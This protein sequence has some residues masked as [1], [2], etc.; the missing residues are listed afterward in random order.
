MLDELFRLTDATLANA[1]PAV[2]DPLRTMRKAVRAH[3]ASAEDEAFLEQYLDS[4][5]EGYLLSNTP[6]EIA[7]HARVA[8]DARESIVTAAIIPSV[9]EEITE[10]CVVTGNPINDPLCVIAKDRPGLLASIAAAITS[11]GFDVHA[12]QIHTRQMSDGR[13]QAMDLF[14]VTSR[15]PIDDLDTALDKLRRDLERVITGAVAPS[16]LLRARRTRFS[17][18]PIPA[19]VTEVTIDN[20]TST[21]HTIVEIVTRDRPGLLFTLART[22]HELDLTIGVAKINT[23]GTRVLD[24]FHVTD[25]SGRKI[26]ESTRGDCVRRALLAALSSPPPSQAST[27]SVRP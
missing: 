26:D 27:P 20:R 23:E 22:F 25:L 5:P 7:L 14:W 24:A 1:S 16:D 11:N 3:W 12:A 2:G 21:T 8:L 15:A 18:R 9:R 6:H 4:M 13:V 10:L 17:D 19:V